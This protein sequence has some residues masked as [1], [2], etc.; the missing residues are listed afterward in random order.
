MDRDIRTANDVASKS[1]PFK[2]M[3]EKNPH[4]WTFAFFNSPRGEEQNVLLKKWQAKQAKILIQ[5]PTNEVIPST[6]PYP[7]LPKEGSI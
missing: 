1:Y 7:I 2:T 4:S 6:V 5:G 3:S